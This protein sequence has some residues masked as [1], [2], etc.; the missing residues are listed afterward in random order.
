MPRRWK[1]TV[2]PPDHAAEPGPA[3]TTADDHTGGDK[4]VVRRGLRHVG[5]AISEQ[6]RIF[7]F[8]VLGSSLYGG[9]TVA[10]AYVIGGITDRVLLPAFADGA[11]TAGALSLAALAIIVVAVF[12][13]LGIL[14]RRLFA[15]IMSYRLMADYRRRVTGQYLRLPLSWHQRHP[16]GQLLSNANSDVESSWFFVSPLPFACGALVMVAITVVVLV[17]TDPLL[18]IVGL[19]VFPLVFVLNAV[20]SQV[21]SPRMAHA[22][23]LRAEVSEIAHESFDA[24]LVVKTLGREADEARRFAVKADELRDGLIAV[25]RVRGLFD[26]MMEALPN[27]GTLAVLLVG[28]ERVAAG[29]TDAGDLVSIAYLFTLLAL[30]IRAIGWVLA[31]LPRALAGFDRVTPVLEATGETPHGPDAAPA[32]TGGAGLGIQGVDFRFTEDAQ[33]TLSGVTFDVVA[34]RTVAVVGPTGSGKS[35][36]AGL[37][38]RL[39]DPHTGQVLLDGVDLRTLREGEVSSQVAFVPQSTFLFD[40]TVRDNVT[41]GA[42][43]SDDEVH[44][45]LRIAAAGSFVAQFPDGL[46]TRVGERGASLSGGQRQRLALARAVVRRPRLLILDDATSAVDPSVEARI[47]DALRA[48]DRPATVVVVAYRQATIA[49]ADEVVWLERGRL[50]ARGSHDELLR[51]VPGY[52][53]LVQAYQP[54]EFAE[55]TDEPVEVGA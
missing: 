34:G 32:G 22:Q 17:L 19:V 29:A 38:V 25:G 27:L 7:T 11:T 42:P 3:G 44:E 54:P 45:A 10:S 31:D 46:D 23:Q 37:L 16:T 21:M 39:V 30:P 48:S 5:R 53:R 43:F 33:P 47:L 14:G 18:A 41:L 9:M 20:Y 35:T 6:P 15:G 49:L 8:A 52:A 36:L 2:P 55:R 50:V 12:K 1:S 24:A 13:I 28:A 40:D 26:P 51:Q 4:R